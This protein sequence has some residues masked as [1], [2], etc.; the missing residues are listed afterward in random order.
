MKN[1]L[2]WRGWIGSYLHAPFQL[3]FILIMVNILVFI[4]DWP[5]GL[6]LLGF[7][8]IYFTIVGY[9]YFNN[10]QKLMDEFVRLATDYERIQKNLLKQMDLPM[11]LLD[12]TGRVIW[13]NDEF[14]RIAHRESNYKKSVTNIFPAIKREVLPIN[15]GK[16]DVPLEFEQN[17]YKAHLQ[18]IPLADLAR[19]SG[20]FKSE[21][22]YDISM[23]SLYLTNTTALNLAL[24]EVDN[25]SVSVGLIYIDNYEEALDSLEDVRQSLLIALI[26]R[27]VN[28]YI[29]S[30]NGICVKLEKDKYLF[31]MTKKALHELQQ[32]RFALL[33]DVKTVNIGNEMAITLS[34]GVGVDGFTYAQNYEFARNAIDLALGRGGDQA[35]LKSPEEVVYY[36]G[37]SQQVE[38]STR[39]KARVKAQALKEIISARD[40]VYIMGHRIGDPDSFGSCVG[41]YR[42]AKYLNRKAHIVLNERT[43]SI[44]QILARFDESGE[45]DDDMILTGSQALEHVSENSALVVVDTNKPS[46]T[47]CPELL[48]LCKSIVVL[49]HHRQGKE[50]IEGATLSYIEPY[51]SSACEMVT[52]IMRYVGDGVKLRP[53]EADA[54]YGGIV[55]DTNNFM[56]RTGVRTFEA[57][58]YL[59]R[60]G[61]DVSR[62]RKMFRDD[63]A[64]Y[65]AKA[66]AVSK[67]EIYKDVYAISDCHSENLKSPTVV[68][69]QA[70]N[71]LLG[72]TGIK[73]SFVLTPYQEKIFISARS[74]DEVNVQLIMERM[75]G[76]GHLNIAGAQL[77]GKTLEEARHELKETIDKMTEEGAI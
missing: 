35:V 44:R 40:V 2:K 75:G 8:I 6:V 17:N 69:A 27:K 37:K 36:G 21:E 60:W 43:T 41:I 59:R 16:V 29:L 33:E 56:N 26:D 77:T 11:A 19:K 65:K 15:S 4:M 31:V 46:I 9:M 55:V 57:A 38:K 72:I 7:M 42:I 5:S 10:R 32:E 28:R 74:I 20:L 48:K 18:H 63:P 67:A 25:Q 62:V 24:Q 30:C 58:A 49:D 66:D 1:H 50:V 70:A 73:A 76:G 54:L 39:V 14:S 51:A 53:E 47:E 61:A 45:Y 22:S 3:G 64:E 68:G 71:E 12:E 52:E 23:I 13:M 34:I